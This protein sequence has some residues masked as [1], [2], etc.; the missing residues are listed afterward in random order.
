[1]ASPISVSRMK[2][3]PGLADPTPL[4]AQA[5]QLLRNSPDRDLHAPPLSSLGLLPSLWTLH[6]L[7]P[8]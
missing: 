5:S 6:P 3:G 4:E 2:Q 8:V 1:M 7:P